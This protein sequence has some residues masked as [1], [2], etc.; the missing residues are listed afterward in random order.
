MIACELCTRSIFQLHTSVAR[1]PSTLQPNLGIIVINR[2][3]IKS[4]HHIFA[5][6]AQK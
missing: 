5:C 1:Q 4:F 2:S 6:V 3:T